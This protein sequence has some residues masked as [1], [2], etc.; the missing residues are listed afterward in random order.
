M[1]E[2]WAKF[3]EAWGD[4]MAS[5]AQLFHLWAAKSYGKSAVLF[6]EE[7]VDLANMAN[8]RLSEMPD[9]PADEPMYPIILEQPGCDPKWVYGAPAVG[10]ATG[11]FRNGGF[12]AEGDFSPWDFSV[13]PVVESEGQEDGQETS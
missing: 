12:E 5:W 13:A 9:L 4:L 6:Y 8:I 10:P 2:Q 3:Y 7:A 11:R 1:R